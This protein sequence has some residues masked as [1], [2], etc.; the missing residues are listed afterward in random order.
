MGELEG[1][2]RAIASKACSLKDEHAPDAPPVLLD[3]VAVYSLSQAD[4]RELC[5]AAQEAG[6]VE[7]STPTGAVFRL[8]PFDTRAGKLELLKIR[9]PTRSK[10]EGGEAGFTVGN[11]AAFKEKYAGRA[12]FKLVTR[13]KLETV[14]LSDEESGVR[15][16]FK[17]S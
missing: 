13:E 4:Y 11:Y 15:A 2:V 1:I 5:S 9:V 14:E 7:A 17:P 8:K 3:Y 6:E 16:C 12:G 10:R